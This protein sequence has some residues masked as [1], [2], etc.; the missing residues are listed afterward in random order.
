LG[1]DFKKGK[2]KGKKDKQG[3]NMLGSKCNPNLSARVVPEGKGGTGMKKNRGGGR[4]WGKRVVGKFVYES[5]F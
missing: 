1:S 3:R 5:W 4:I 2:L